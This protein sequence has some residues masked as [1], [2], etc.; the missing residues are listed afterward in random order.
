MSQILSVAEILQLRDGDPIPSCRVRFKKI[1]EYKD[2]SNEHGPWSFQNC[3]VTDGAGE[4]KLKLKNRPQLTKEWTNIMVVF[5]AVPGDKKPWLG[6]SKQTEEYRGRTSTVIVVDDRATMTQDTG[7][8]GA[9]QAPQPANVAPA[10]QSQSQPPVH[11]QHPQQPT[12]PAHAPA[13]PAQPAQP[14]S[15]PPPRQQQA[16][17]APGSP[18]DQKECIRKARVYTGKLANSLLIAFDAAMY[19]A[20]NVDRKH[21]IQL[22][23]DEIE[24]MAIS[25]NIALERG[26][27]VDGLPEGAMDYNPKPT[28][29][30]T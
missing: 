22:T 11:P 28:Q 26:G 6:M 2:G 27:Y 17:P 16:R 29:P 18:E 25:I 30:T 9:E 8:F 10:P 5:Q 19:V 14:V 23:T 12:Q 15:Q 4:I 3:T 13:A 7:Q 1:T 24:R 20:G 21:K